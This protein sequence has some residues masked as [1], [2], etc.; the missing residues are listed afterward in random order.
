MHNSKLNAKNRSRGS[1]PLSSFPCKV[2]RLV[3]GSYGQIKDVNFSSGK[4]ASEHKEW[5]AHERIRTVL[6]LPVG[7]LL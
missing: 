4:Q 2:L 5:D 7:V 3:L 1:L 6:V